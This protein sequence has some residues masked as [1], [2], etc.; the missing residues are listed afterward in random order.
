MDVVYEP[1]FVLVGVGVEYVAAA[2]LTVATAAVSAEPV[3]VAAVY[4]TDTIDA[5]LIVQL[6]DTVLLYA[7]VPVMDVVYDPAFVLVGVGVE[8]VAALGVTLA[9][10]A[11]NA[12]PVYVAAV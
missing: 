1:A 5:G 4:V 8:Y 3:Y 10:V 12:E 7:P 11:V 2:G 6:A 9:T